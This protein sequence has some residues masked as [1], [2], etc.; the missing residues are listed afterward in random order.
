MQLLMKNVFGLLR[1]YAKT[2]N[3]IRSPNNFCFDFIYFNM[4]GS[5]CK[6]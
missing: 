2:V 1:F 3:I 4:S 6:S 5:S